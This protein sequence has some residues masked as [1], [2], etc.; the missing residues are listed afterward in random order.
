MSPKAQFSTGKK[1]MA[2]L[3]V[4]IGAG[5]A[6]SLWS[7]YY[8]AILQHYNIPL[9]WGY[10]APLALLTV[11]LFGGDACR[12]VTAALTMRFSLSDMLTTVSNSATHGG[13]PLFRLDHAEQESFQVCYQ[14]IWSRLRLNLRRRLLRSFPVVYYNVTAKP[15]LNW[16]DYLYLRLLHDLR[17]QSGAHIIVALHFDEAIYRQGFFTDVVRERYEQLL[18]ESK[19]LIE[20][21][22]GPQVEVLDEGALIRRRAGTARL[23]T[24]YFFGV[25]IA[26]LNEVVSGVEAGELSFDQFYRIE[27][28]LISILP[29]VLTARRYGHLF[30]LDYEGSFDVWLHSPFP[31][32]KHRHR[33]FFIKCSRIQGPHGERLPAWSPEDGVN[34]TDD[35]DTV[36]Q[37][38]ARLDVSVLDAMR[39]VFGVEGH[40]TCS[41]TEA[42]PPL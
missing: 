24:D 22:V 8:E 25:M 1:L 39:D 40:R 37:K 28:N 2:G 23:F 29:T 36:R 30:V 7:S 33:L 15:F 9:L 6:E 14:S 26:H 27:T 19:R 12:W 35:T 3:L 5:A 42:Q 38:I 17:T 10:I 11:V 21:V 4:L 34:I 16:I 31:E 41:R 20:K 13:A 32:F 18:N